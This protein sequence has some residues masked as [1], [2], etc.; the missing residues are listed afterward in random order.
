MSSTF[1]A[2]AQALGYIYQARLALHLILHADEEAEII[3]EGLDDV[4][5]EENGQPQELLQ[6]KHHVTNEAKLTDSSPELWRSLRVWSTHFSENSITIPQ[7]ILTLVTTAA[8]PEGSIASFL[9]QDSR[10]RNPSLAEKK[11]VEVATTSSNQSLSS[12]F[13]A[14]LDLSSHERQHLVGAIQILDLSP[15]ISDIPFLIKKRIEVATRRQYLDNLYERLEGWWFGQ[16]IEQLNS[17]SPVPIQRLSVLS[18]V[19]DIAEQFGEDILP[20]DYWDWEPPEPPDP[21]SDERIFVLQLRAISL[22]TRRI[23]KAIIDYYRAFEQRS[24]WARDDLLI[25]NEVE[26]YE[27]LLIDEWERFYLKLQQ[28]L[29]SDEEDED[30]LQLF[31]RNVFDWVD[32][33]ADFRIRPRVAKDYIMRGS[34]HMLANNKRVWWHPKFVER[35]EAVL[36]VPEE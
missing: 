36:V 11:L 35:L 16:V 28:D 26:K 27:R 24:R 12:A 25:G 33:K 32:L 20:M 29:G 14:F 21:E 18:K 31:G 8:A 10:I 22:L 3:I 6:L 23:E 1:S 9:S 7:T 4:V 2:G 13:A 5:F 19:R 30:A 34:Y 15:K 17:Q